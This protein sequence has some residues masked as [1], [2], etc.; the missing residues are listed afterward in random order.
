MKAYIANI[1]SYCEVFSA[2]VSH[3][4]PRAYGSKPAQSWLK[5]WGW[6]FQ[7]KNKQRKYLYMRENFEI[8]FYSCNKILR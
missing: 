3:A 4:P 6:P 8:V 2:S 5:K 1:Y 7:K